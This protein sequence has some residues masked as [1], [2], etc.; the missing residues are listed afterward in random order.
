MRYADKYGNLSAHDAAVMALQEIEK[1]MDDEAW[2]YLRKEEFKEWSYPV[3]EKDYDLHKLF[4][5]IVGLQMVIMKNSGTLG[6]SKIPRI[7][8]PNGKDDKIYT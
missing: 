3:S 6:F 5:E 8:W 2:E 7:W 4:S 1:Y